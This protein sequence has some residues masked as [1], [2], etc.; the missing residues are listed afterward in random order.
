MPSVD[1][2]V[3]PA[4]ERRD[5]GR[6]GLGG[7]Q[8]LVRREA[9][10][11]VGLDALVGAGP[12]RLEALGDERHLDDDVVAQRGELAGLLHHRR[13]AWSTRP[14]PRPARPRRR[15][16]RRSTSRNLR[17][18][19]A[20][21]DG[22][23]VTPSTS[24][25]A[26]ASLISSMSAVSMKNFICTTAFTDGRPSGSS[27][28]D[29]TPPSTSSWSASLSADTSL[30][31]REAG[32]GRLRHLDQVGEV[33]FE[34]ACLHSR[35]LRAATRAVNAGRGTGYA[36]GRM[37]IGDP[38][39]A[40]RRER[41]GRG[42]RVISVGCVDLPHGMSRR[43]Y[44]QKLRFLETRLPADEVPSERI[45]RR[46]RN[47]AGAGANSRWSRRA[48]AEPAAGPDRHR[49]GRG[50]GSRVP[51][52]GRRPPTPAPPPWCSPPRRP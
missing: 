38:Q 3:E 8:R 19:L 44:F 36:S 7:E 32:T 15:R 22:L 21:S 34:V 52:R 43:V 33:S 26:A 30:H 18:V 14:R 17:P 2:V 24:P 42:A 16:S 40:R 31:G 29:T 51:A 5:V 4:D 47:E 37:P 23:V 35:T 9:E 48:I 45:M 50:R 25:I 20:T 6:A 12:D 27:T 10:R 41:R 49:A 13:R 11:D 28:P 39:P 1:D 46:W